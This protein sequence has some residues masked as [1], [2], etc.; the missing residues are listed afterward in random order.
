[1][2]TFMNALTGDDYTMYPFS[3][4]NPTD[5][6][7]LMDVYMD[8]TFSPR[9][10]ELDFKQEGWRLEH[11]D[12]KDTKSPLI[13]KGV[14]YNEMKGALA[15]QSALFYYRNQQSLYPKTI[16]SHVSG[17]DPEA[18]TDLTHKQL[19][20]F[21]ARNYHPSN[22]RFFT[23]GTF[24]LADHLQ[25]VNE[26]IASFEPIATETVGD[27]QFF[28][29]P[30]R[31][32]ATCP[33]DPMGNPEKQT[34]MAV[35]FV[36]NRDI[37]VYESFAMRVL[38]SLLLEGAASPMFKALIESNIGSDYAAT[39]GYNSHTRRTNVSFGLQGIR[40]EDVDMVEEKIMNVLQQAAETGFDSRRVESVI[41]Q[42]ELGLKHRKANFGMTLGQGVMSHWVHGGDP[43]DALEMSKYIARL[44]TD[45]Q[46]DPAYF[47]KMIHKQFLENKHRLT[48]V[49]EP[50]NSYNQILA[51]K[52]QER[53]KKK[54]DALTE[55]DRKVIYEQGL[56]LVK[57]QEEKEDLSCLPTLTEKD[58]LKRG[59]EYPVEDR[60][61]KDT[62]VQFRATATNGVSYVTLAKSLEGLPDELKAYI[63][64]YCSALP[65]LGTKS[66]PLAELDE[67]IRLHTGGISASPSITSSP[68]NL[69]TTSQTLHFSTNALDTN[70]DK[71]YELLREVIEEAKWDDLEKLRTVILGSASD[72]TNSVAQM[73]HKYAMSAASRGLTG[74]G[75]E[76]E[77]VSGLEQVIF[78][79]GLAKEDGEE[80]LRGIS[81]KLKQISEF[82]L[83]SPTSTK[84]AV[85]SES[86]MQ[87]RHEKALEGVVGRLGWSSSSSVSAEST[88]PPQ[89]EKTFFP[90]PFGVNFAARSFLG[91]PY[92]HEDG[93]ALQILASLLT[94]HFLHREIREKG[95]AYGGG[96]RYSAADGVLS[97]YSYRD[98]PGLKRT[99]D[100]FN[101]SEE[102]AEKIRE[103]VGKRELEEAKL[104]VFQSIDK[105]ISAGSEGMTRF[106]TGITDEMRQARRECLFAVTLED[107]ERVAK[108][109]FVG[110]A[111]GEAVLGDVMEREGLG[112]GWKVVEFAQ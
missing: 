69:H 67:A 27:V 58:I 17:G 85:I 46:Q 12:P 34:K 15:D 21:H 52:E 82:V 45:L 73:G 100:T 56:Q 13:F 66:K 78:M 92:T 72:G 9:L 49:M 81:E 31:I 104:S 63:P 6:K 19:T 89:P 102:W 75:R 90:L 18:I 83:K 74:A 99:L 65:S 93:A 101:R 79:N 87:Q 50:E 1:M 96:A 11:E 64:L 76:E 86:E 8:S 3:T 48:F 109:Y 105:P 22:A 29:S 106:E 44:R 4:E 95:G 7:N 62:S 14:V 32:T 71:A 68:Q 97:L 24:P 20:D 2:A 57:N 53:L 94:N 112:E 111:R 88:T 10:R 55:E 60:N 47:Q 77:R 40:S 37:E 84:A 108:K 43:L 59:K 41:H 23:Y 38:S 33:P 80:E 91:V 36:T 103:R 35:S 107:V 5:F 51:Q 28:D 42:M 61:V 98:P 26:K 70:V 110:K 16:Y 25:A 54:V 39:T 30:Q